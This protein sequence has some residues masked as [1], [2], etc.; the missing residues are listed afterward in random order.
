MVAFKL[1]LKNLYRNIKHTL[2]LFFVFLVAAVMAVSFFIFS[3][4]SEAAYSAILARQASTSFVSVSFSTLSFFNK[5]GTSYTQKGDISPT[6]LSEIEGIDGVNGVYHMCT[7]TADL[8][9]SLG[10]SSKMDINISSLLTEGGDMPEPF[11]KE[12]NSLYSD[13]VLVCGGWA[14]GKENGCLVSESFVDLTGA[15]SAE[16]LLGKTLATYVTLYN[17]YDGSSISEGQY[18]EE[19]VITGVVSK[20]FSNISVMESYSENFIFADINSLVYQFSFP[21]AYLV[22]GDYADLDNIKQAVEEL[23]IAGSNIIS[24]SDSYAMKKLSQMSQFISAIL[25]IIATV[26]LIACIAVITG[27]S[28][29]KFA[30]NRAFYYAAFAAGLSKNKLALS[31]LYEFCIVAAISFLVALPLGGLLVK[32]LVSVLSLYLG[33]VFVADMS[34]FAALYSL[35]PLAAAGV[36]ATAMVR[37]KMVSELRSKN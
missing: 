2:G 31:F 15:E 1:A 24:G 20:N 17:V 32:G 22:Y 37:G 21:N 13:G 27:A 7:D 11:V 28:M 34:V 35:V 26:C 6:E 33:A 23:D 30:K 18:L 10:G 9:V 16:D 4:M 3:D 14:D 36:I 29:L 19:L 12:Y 8:H 5:D 25:V